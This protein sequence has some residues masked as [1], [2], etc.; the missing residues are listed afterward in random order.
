MEEVSAHMH[1]GPIV[2]DVLIRQHEHRFGL[3]WSV[4]HETCFTD[5]QCRRFGRNL[6]QYYNTTPRRLVKKEPLEA[7][8]LRAFTG[9]KTDDDLI[10]RAPLGGA[11]QIGG[12][13]VLVQIW[14]WL[15]IP[16]LQP[17]LMTDVHADPLAPLGAIWCTSFDCS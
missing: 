2:P 1:P 3:I 17:Q 13:L 6:F 15:H 16:A 12:A 7:W 4:D 10:L 5:L 8:I 9:S 14:A 11:R